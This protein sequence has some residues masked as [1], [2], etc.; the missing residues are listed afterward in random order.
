[1]QELQIKKKEDIAD[2]KLTTE[3]KRAEKKVTL[4][5]RAQQVVD[6]QQ[7]SLAKI[8]EENVKF[9]EQKK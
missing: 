3:A 5:S 6:Q 4:R 8:E 7:R 2:R 9:K 1:M